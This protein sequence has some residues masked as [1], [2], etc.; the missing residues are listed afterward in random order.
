MPPN[1]PGKSKRSDRGAAGRRTTM[2]LEGRVALVTGAGSGI[3][4][5]VA[6]RSATAGAKVAVNSRSS[7]DP[8]EDLVSRIRSA[9]GVASSI[10]A[11]VSKDVEVQAMLG[12]GAREF[13][14]LCVLLHNA[15]WSTRVPHRNLDQLTDDIWD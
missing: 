7:R 5:A 14:R 9:G 15:G 4:R 10:Q 11:D 3:G 12:R 2:N 13:G 6:E 8:A 1:L